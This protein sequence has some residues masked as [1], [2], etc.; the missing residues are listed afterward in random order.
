[1]RCVFCPVVLT[2]YAHLKRDVSFSRY[3]EHIHALLAK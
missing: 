1:M 3:E 2:S